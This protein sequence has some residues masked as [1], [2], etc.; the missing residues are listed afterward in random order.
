MTMW[1]NKKIT[2]S[3]LVVF[4]VLL[5][6]PLNSALAKREKLLVNDVEFSALDQDCRV[7]NIYWPR[8]S[9]QQY[10]YSARAGFG[11]L[12]DIDGDGVHTDTVVLW[13]KS[14]EGKAGWVDPSTGELMYSSSGD[15]P[16]N[17][18]KSDMS[19]N[20]EDL[21]VWPDFDRVNGEPIQ[22][23]DQDVVGAMQDIYSTKYEDLPYH[24]G[25]QYVVH[26]WS[27]ARSAAKDFVFVD[28]RVINRSQYLNTEN[29]TGPYLWKNCYWGLRMD[30]DVGTNASDDRS[31]FMKE[32]N[33]GFTFDRD[34]N[35]GGK[36]YGFMGVRILKTPVVNGEELGLTNWTAIQNASGN[37][38]VPDPRD[39]RSEYRI[40]SKAP[41]Q[42]LDPVYDPTKDYQFSGVVGD[43]RQ[44]I[45]SG[46]FDMNQ[47]DEVSVTISFLFAN[48]VNASPK[49]GTDEEIIGELGNLTNTADAVKM[50][51]DL[52]ELAKGPENPSITLIPGDGNVTLTWDAVPSPP[53]PNIEIAEYR[54]YR[55]FNAA[56][57]DY[58]LLK[59]VEPGSGAT[60][61]YTDNS[62]ELVNGW[63]AYY[64]VTVLDRLSGELGELLGA[65]VQ[66]RAPIFSLANMVIPRSDALALSDRSNLKIRVVPNPFLA[67]AAWDI[68][69]TE[70]H[71][72]FINLPAKCT[73]RIFTISGN[74]VNVVQHTNDS[75][76]ENYN[77]RNRFNELIASG[78]Y[79][80]VVTEPGGAKETGRFM[81]V[82]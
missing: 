44:L 17:S 40:L 80:Y 50:F 19:V 22:R 48:A 54:I 13:Q 12:L 76:T 9:G 7:R 60:L 66:E 55:S 65:G 64:T 10:L 31:G 59:T 62:A 68:S 8:G 11:A 2:A 33:L 3:I 6:I 41:G 67:Q 75:G 1:K 25:I 36:P 56:A 34:F 71:V 20:E 32:K 57:E 39:D 73:I 28:Y 23:G 77:L 5:L 81:V 45:A 4:A 51:Y 58:V 46:P 47:D 49:Y 16:W 78:I 29:Q 52:G 42:T 35:D 74:L 70:K 18:L 14:A 38:I 15:S 79:Y 26:A 27:F 37:Y 63:K 43:T 30:P 72:Q 53:N 24:L 82:R 21:G 69:A 61:S